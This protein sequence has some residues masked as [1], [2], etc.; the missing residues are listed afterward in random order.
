VP[1]LSSAER[2]LRHRAV[3]SARANV[4]L[5]GACLS[6]EIEV[7][8]ARYIAGNLS[9]REHIDALLDHAYTLPAGKPVQEYFTSLDEAVKAAPTR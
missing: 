4:E 6:P 1:D 3:K 7:L 2:L 5:S 9:D 8:L